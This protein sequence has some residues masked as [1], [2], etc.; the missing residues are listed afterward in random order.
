MK[1]IGSRTEFEYRSALQ[2]SHDLLFQEGSKL[3]EA[4][5][6]AGHSTDRAYVLS[7]VPDQGDEYFTV[8]VDGEYVLSG[9]IELDRNLRDVIFTRQNLR[10]YEKG[11]GRSER[12]KLLVA[13]D[14]AS[15]VNR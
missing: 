12:I 6:C 5:E 1:L 2:S 11:L 9:E 15:D 10:E 14:M 13:M 8:L 3:K 7:W 4:L